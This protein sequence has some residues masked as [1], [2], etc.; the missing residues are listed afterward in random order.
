MLVLGEY[1]VNDGFPGHAREE[2]PVAR[3]EAS[4]MLH[5]WDPL[6]GREC[7]FRYHGIDIYPSDLAASAVF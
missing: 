3:R 6:G 1:S 7:G 5:P 2:M 4:R